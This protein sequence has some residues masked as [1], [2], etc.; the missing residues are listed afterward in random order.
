MAYTYATFFDVLDYELKQIREGGDLASK[1]AYRCLPSDQAER[2]INESIKDLILLN[3]DRFEQELTV[4]FKASPSAGDITEAS[5]GTTYT[6][7]DRIVQILSARIDNNWFLL[8][9]S[10]DLNSTIY[11][12]SNKTITNVDGW[13]EDDTITFKVILIPEN[14]AT[15]PTGDITT[16]T[17]TLEF[18]DEYIRLL[19]LDVKRR[20]YARKGNGLSQFEYIEYQEL[21]NRWIAEK[22]RVRKVARV[23]F[24]GYGFG[25]G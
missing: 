24:R 4:T 5:T 16:N 11:S 6:A 20:S 3:L 23:A 7:P 9:D 15:A 8:G 13:A 17:D 22:G 18:P 12:T 1:D 21:R 14:A 10:S 25:R 2:I 19:I